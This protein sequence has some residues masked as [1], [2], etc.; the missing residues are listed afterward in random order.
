MD[1]G[2]DVI[3]LYLTMAGV[4]VDAIA[5]PEVGAAWDRPSVLEEQT[6]GSVA[7]HLARGGVWL[8]DDYLDGGVPAGPED[9]DS[10]GEYFAR[11]AAHATGT[12]EQAIR[13]RGAAIAQAGHAAVADEARTRFVEVASRLRT[14]PTDVLVTVVGGSVMRLGDYLETRLVEQVVHLDDLAR[15]L[16]RDPYPVPDGATSMVLSIGIDVARRCFGDAAVLRAIYRNGF[17][18]VTFPIF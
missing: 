4:V 11:F 17:A 15:G 8:V 9:I 16:G 2:D 1:A 5:D 7:G 10:A 6:I 3:G 18:E 14:T 12:S 13:D